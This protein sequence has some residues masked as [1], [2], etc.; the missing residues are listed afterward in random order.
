MGINVVDRKIELGNELES[1]S[2][3]IRNVI[4]AMIRSTKFSD[5]PEVRSIFFETY[6]N[7][8]VEL[9]EKIRKDAME[10]FHVSEISIVQRVGQIP[11]GDYSVLVSVAARRIDDA[12]SACKFIVEEINSE[13]PIWKYEVKNSETGGKPPGMNQP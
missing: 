11:L 7:M 3:E 2:T 13:L 8:A 5:S 4:T 9:M 12:F 10:R 1:G 6:E